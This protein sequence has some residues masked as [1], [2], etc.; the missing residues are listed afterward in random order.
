MLG[1]RKVRSMQLEYNAHI[2]AMKDPFKKANIN[3]T[4]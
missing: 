2:G 1:Y 4:K 3:E